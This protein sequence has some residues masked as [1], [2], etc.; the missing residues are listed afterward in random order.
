MAHALR[1]IYVVL[2]MRRRLR[3]DGTVYMV[4]RSC[5]WSNGYGLVLQL[6]LGLGLG[7]G[8]GFHSLFFSLISFFF[9]KL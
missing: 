5:M 4:I 6:G 3:E 9:S 8:N 7:S 1:H 2:R